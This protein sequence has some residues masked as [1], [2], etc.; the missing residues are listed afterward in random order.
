MV[1]NHN[2]EQT[3]MI[4]ESIYKSPAGKSQ[5]MALYEAVLAR[6]PVPYETFRLPTRHGETFVI[7]SGDK[8]AP[9][10]VLL[11]GSASN[12]VSWVGEVPVYSQ[13]FCVYAVDL[14]G[15]P[16]KSAEN[17]PAWDGPG[18]AEWLEDVLDVLKIQKTALL[19]ISQGGWTA[20]KFATTRPERVVKLVLLAP[21][22]VMPARPSFLLKAVFLSMFGRW[23]AE[24]IN[25]LVIGKDPIH[26]EAV[27][28][29]NAIL[30]HFKA[31]VGKEYLFPDD[32][33][34]RLSMPTLLIGGAEDALIPMESVIPR[35]QKLV[36][37][38]E[39]VLIPE[40]GHALINQAERILPFLRQ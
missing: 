36:P 21:G 39:P 17:R 11:H 13:H 34:K 22:G 26:P 16:G 7:A 30:T 14:P 15:E 28:F 23:G 5:I 24:R 18:F 10:L 6:W 4:T 19:G 29:M 12:A 32:E 40:M 35:M 8:S 27:R 37:Q 33:L 20:L 1:F 9:P 31:R 3:T 25:R 38:L 2:G